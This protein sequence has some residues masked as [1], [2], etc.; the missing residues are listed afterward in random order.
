MQKFTKQAKQISMPI[1]FMPVL[2]QDIGKK[3]C[4]TSFKEE[5]RAAYTVYSELHSMAR[6]KGS[7]VQSFISKPSLKASVQSNMANFAD[8]QDP[9]GSL[10]E[11]ICSHRSSSVGFRQSMRD[12]MASRLAQERK[13]YE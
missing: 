5:A 1:S 12:K 4:D 10:N 3:S 2:K 8:H 7:P 11:G 9:K 6:P 13:K